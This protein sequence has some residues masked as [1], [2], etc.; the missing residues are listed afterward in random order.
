MKNAI[1][2][3]ICALFAQPFVIGAF[4]LLF[5]CQPL[6]VGPFVPEDAI[7]C[8]YDGDCPEATQC[9]F[10]GVGRDPVCMPGSNAAFPNLTPGP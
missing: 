7:P 2:A 10:P 5:G 1:F 9:R 3:G 6:Q 4:L 8:R